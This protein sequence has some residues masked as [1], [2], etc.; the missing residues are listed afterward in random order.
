[1]KKAPIISV[2]FDSTL[3]RKDVQEYVLELITA[4]IDVWVVTSRYDDLH[5]HLWASNAN[6]D[7]LFSVT[8]SLGIPRHKVR[9]T[10]TQSKSIYLANTHIIW[11]LD[12]DPIELL[13][14][15]EN[16]R[17]FTAGINVEHNLW[18]ENCEKL[19]KDFLF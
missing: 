15:R 1:M 9:F 13:E 12:D 17:V 10:N 19:L 2:D 6:N 3:T 4:G 11:H 18:K 16:P 7:G 14:M 5:G 8:D